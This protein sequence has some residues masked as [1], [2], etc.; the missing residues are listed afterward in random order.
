MTDETG[1]LQRRND[2]ADKQ[3][4]ILVSARE[5]FIARGFEGTS[6]SA[7]ARHSGVTQSMIHHYFGSKQGLWDAVKNEAFASYLEQQK[8]LFNQEE[9]DVEA[10]I[11]GALGGRFSFFRDNPDMVRLLS[12]IQLSEDP[13]GMETGPEIGSQV[14][15]RIRRLQEKGAAR[16]DVAAEYI[17]A[18]ALALTTYWYQ[19]R[20]LIK[21]FAGIREEDI[22]TAGNEYIEAVIRVFSDSIVGSIK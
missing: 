14:I 11:A 16:D 1:S 15:E 10:L 2:P 19:N 4:R 20:Q 18:M 12:W 7:V 22:E 13:L 21:T 3:A 6:M 9:S 17:F 8:A 5:L